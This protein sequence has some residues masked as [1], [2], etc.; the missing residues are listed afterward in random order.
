MCDLMRSWPIGPRRHADDD[1]ALDTGC[2][3]DEARAVHL[4]APRSGTKFLGFLRLHRHELFDDAFQDELAAMY[5]TTGAG[6]EARPPA[7]MAMATL[8]QGYWASPTPR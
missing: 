3:P 2:R 8:V 4:E 1:R 7:M 6:K 5:R